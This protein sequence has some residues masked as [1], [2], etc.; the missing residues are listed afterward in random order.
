MKLFSCQHRA[1]NRAEV[2]HIIQVT[3]IETNGPIGC[4]NPGRDEMCPFRN[5]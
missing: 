1:V 2:I 5:Q 3:A 4:P